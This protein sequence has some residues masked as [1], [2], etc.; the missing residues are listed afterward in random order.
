ML[1]KGH[2]KEGEKHDK[3]MMILAIERRRRRRRR[4]KKR[5]EHETDNKRMMRGRKKE[6][7]ETQK[8]IKRNRL[9]ESQFETNKTFYREECRGDRVFKEHVKRIP[10]LTRLKSGCLLMTSLTDNP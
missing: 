2:G 6:A 1:K 5:R 7:G 4:R 8:R 3:M 10:Y 9:K